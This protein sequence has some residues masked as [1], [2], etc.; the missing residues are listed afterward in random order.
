MATWFS[1]LLY[2][3]LWRIIRWL[4]E[5][6]AYAS[7]RASASLIHKRNGRRVQRMRQNYA[8]ANPGTTPSELESLVHEGLCNAMRYWCDTFRIGDWSKEQISKT[9]QTIHEE[10]LVEG[11]KSG[12]GLI[13]ALPHAGNWDHAGLYFCSKGI[14]VHTVAEHLKPEKLFQRFLAHREAMGMRVFDLNKD[15]I[16]ELIEVLRNGGLVALVADRDL[17]KSGIDVEFLGGNA[18]M[19]AGPALL[20]YRTGADLI[21]AYV[22]YTPSGIEIEFEGPFSV[23]RK[24]DERS[25]VLRVTQALADQFGSNIR[26]NPTSWQMMQRIFVDRLEEAQK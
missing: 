2:S 17:S 19:P 10:L 21:T 22:S 6:L 7:A 3:A 8:Q 4:P 11:V 23:N 16:G 14:T 25:E 13:V 12:R 15:V 26:A 1:Y 5:E 24:E 9:V 20:A 18:R